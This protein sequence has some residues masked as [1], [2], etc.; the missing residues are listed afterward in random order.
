MADPVTG[1][2]SVDKV[3]SEVVTH[4]NSVSKKASKTALL[5][6][7][8]SLTL[9]AVEAGSGGDSVNNVLQA[10]VRSKLHRGR[11]IDRDWRCEAYVRVVLV[12]LLYAGGA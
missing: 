7:L 10:M 11:V 9:F 1:V 12:P 6:L 3:V 4:S 5:P 8:R 2:E